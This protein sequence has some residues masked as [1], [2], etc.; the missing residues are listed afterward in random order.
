MDID[1]SGFEEIHEARNLDAVPEWGENWRDYRHAILIGDPTS[2]G[3]GRSWW[4]FSR[5][6]SGELGERTLMFAAQNV[7]AAAV[8]GRRTLWRG[9]IFGERRYA[10]DSEIHHCL[11]RIARSEPGWWRAIWMSDE[12][13]YP[14]IGFLLTWE[15]FDRG[16]TLT[17]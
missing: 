2:P 1:I 11:S 9:A 12:A 17:I 4:V 10:E 6:T 15:M 13:I 5:V 16:Q 14:A 3:L 8:P 7:V